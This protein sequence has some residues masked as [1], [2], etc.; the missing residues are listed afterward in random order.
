[1][2]YTGIIKVQWIFFLFCINFGVISAQDFSIASVTPGSREYSEMRPSLEYNYLGICNNGV[3]RYD[4]H[5]LDIISFSKR[6]QKEVVTLLSLED[7]NNLLGTNTARL[8]YFKIHNE[9]TLYTTLG[10]TLYLFDTIDRTI[11]KKYAFDSQRWDHFLISPKADYIVLLDGQNIAIQKSAERDSLKILMDDASDAIVYGQS[12]HRNE[13]GIKKGVFFSPSGASFAF[14]RNDQSKIKQYPLVDFNH[15][16]AHL[17][18]IRY[19]MSGED[20]EEV[21]IGIYSVLENKL[22]GY[23]DLNQEKYCYQIN[24]TYIDEKSIIVE[25][26]N[27]EQNRGIT[28]LY[29]VQRGDLLATY[30]PE[31]KATY[32]EP[33]QAVIPVFDKKYNGFL[34][35][36]RNDGY[37]HLYYVDIKKPKRSKQLTKGA[38]EIIEVLGIRRDRVYFTSNKDDILGTD[39][40]S[41]RLDGTS[42][43]KIE[44]LGEGDKAFSFST[45]SDLV[46][47][48][49]SNVNQPAQVASIDLR[50]RECTLLEKAELPENFSE[51]P[52]V[53]FGTIK[54]EDKR[55]DL[56]YKLTLPTHFDESK[57]Y[58]V[59]LYV[60]GGP[61]SQLVRN[62]WYM[63]RGNFDNYLAQEGFIVFTLDNRGTDNR[64]LDFESITHRNLGKYEMADQMQGIRYLKTLPYVD[65]ERIGVYGWSFGGFMATNLMLSYPEIFKVGVAGG[66]VMDWGLYEVMYGERYMDTPATNPVGYEQSNLIKRAKELQGRLLLIHGTV[67]PVVLWQHSQEFVDAAIKSDKLVDYMIYPGHEH[68][69][70]GKDRTHLNQTIFRFLNDH[71]K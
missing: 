27:R 29:D 22:F 63:T 16:N 20:S 43:Q 44:T 15:P 31:N 14:Y 42:F 52:T 58:P 17:R 51:Y 50:T 60:Y 35:I 37:R 53:S 21:S 34:K 26:L 13:F 41:V 33:V 7:W 3:L 59:L 19:P 24:P 10:D 54:S 56:Y 66:P 23:L 61:H 67:D 32:V 46:L 55:F 12:V 39:L 6:G 69:V 45:N 40:Y 28:A 57:K 65:S 8:P 5:S 68:N 62:N 71:L 49:H 47:V 38:W 1:M 18:E 48:N 4:V 11:I 30:N 2:K 9:Q 36:S 70:L 25:H 64:G